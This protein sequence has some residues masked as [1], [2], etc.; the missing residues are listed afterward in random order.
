LKVETIFTEHECLISGYDE[1][2]RT[3]ICSD[4]FSEQKYKFIEISCDELY[5]SF[6]SL[7]VNK[8]EYLLDSIYS[9]KLSN[10]KVSHDYYSYYIMLCEY[11][12]KRQ[13]SLCVPMGL[14]VYELLIE[15]IKACQDT[16]KQLDYR[17]FSLI[18]DHKTIIIRA[19]NH[20]S[21]YIDDGLFTFTLHNQLLEIS[22]MV[23]RLVY[24]C[25]KK[26]NFDYSKIIDLIYQ[27]REIEESIIYEAIINFEIKYNIEPYGIY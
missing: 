23:N 13:C 4:F 24:K 14:H 20:I 8:D 2:K 21:R 22:K 9:I 16:R 10:Q 18:S 1:E 3:F 26:N 11:I 25:V 15:Y 5:N 6:I 27:M 17:I 19:M 12:G 7:S